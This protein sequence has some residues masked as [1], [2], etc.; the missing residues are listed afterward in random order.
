[1][2]TNR[3]TATAS[4]SQLD[5]ESTQTTQ[6]ERAHAADVALAEL[7]FGELR[8]NILLPAMLAVGG[9]AQ[10]MGIEFQIEMDDVDK[11][12]TSIRFFLPGPSE[13]IEARPSLAI[14]FDPPYD[15]VSFFENDPSA[16][17]SSSGGAVG[18]IGE[19]AFHQVTRE[20]VE[21]RLRGLLAR[22]L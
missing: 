13:G 18:P 19:L 10:E 1:M 15:T 11:L 8:D 20:V 6:D 9:K 17:G 4:L 5:S 2:R 7:R 3:E 14:V 16:G 12:R 21:D 22:A